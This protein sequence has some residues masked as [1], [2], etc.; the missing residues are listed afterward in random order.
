MRPG[1]AEAFAA[2]LSPLESASRP[3]RTDAASVPSLSNL[4]E[5]VASVGKYRNLGR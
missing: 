2:E 4:A 5:L 3:T 1:S